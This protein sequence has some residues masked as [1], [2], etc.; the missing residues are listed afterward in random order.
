MHSTGSKFG[1]S[2][3]YRPVGSPPDHLGVH[4]FETLHEIFHVYEDLE[5]I[6]RTDHTIS[7][8]GLANKIT[9]IRP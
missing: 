6:L 3:F 4:N 9:A 5:G 2:G 7:F 1:K 8:L